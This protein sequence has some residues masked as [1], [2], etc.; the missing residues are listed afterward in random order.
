TVPTPRGLPSNLPIL[1][2]FLVLIFS[3][4]GR[5]AEVRDEGRHAVAARSLGTRRLPWRSVVALT[6]FAA[7]LPALISPTRLLTASITL[8]FVLIIASLGLLV[9]LSRQVSL[10]HAVFTAMGA[11]V[12]AH[13]QHAGVP[14]LPALLLAGLAVVP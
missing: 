14:F 11:A 12:L 13:L 6:A 1:V 5:F 7:V 10:C 3:K 2:L 8:V 9:G 4:K